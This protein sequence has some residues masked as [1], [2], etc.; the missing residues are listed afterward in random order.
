MGTTSHNR[1]V[2]N[3]REPKWSRHWLMVHPRRLPRGGPSLGER[4]VCDDQQV[5][6]SPQASII[7][8]NPEVVFDSAHGVPQ[9]FL[10][11]G[12]VEQ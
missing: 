8:V 5:V 11:V 6:C 9:G 1:C 4:A 7:R 10:I 12:P 2:T 3:P